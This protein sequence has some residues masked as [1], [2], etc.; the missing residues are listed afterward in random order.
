MVNLTKLEFIVL[1]I[2][3]DNYLSWP[4]DVEIHVS[5]K[6]L[7]ETIIEPNDCSAKEKAKAMIFIHHHIHEHLKMEYLTIKEPA[8]LWKKLKERNEH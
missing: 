1:D 4:L 2:S 7:T 5:T 8:I 6:S 3:R